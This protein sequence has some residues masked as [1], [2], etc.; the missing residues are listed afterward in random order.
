MI[1]RTD[2]YHYDDTSTK[3]I[4]NPGSAKYYMSLPSAVGWVLSV[5]A[6]KVGSCTWKNSTKIYAQ[7][8]S[9]IA[10]YHCKEEWFFSCFVWLIKKIKFWKN[11]NS[12]WSFEKCRKNMHV[13][14]NHWKLNVNLQARICHK[15]P[16]Q[17]KI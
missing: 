3:L 14:I 8:K 1:W 10:M 12:W 2:T 13:S 16:K 6:V 5:S 4:I 17:C 11:V 9:P 15:I 7:I